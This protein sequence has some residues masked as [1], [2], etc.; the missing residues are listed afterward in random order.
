MSFVATDPKPTAE[1]PIINDGFWPDVS[2][3]D[4]RT[5]MRLDT[6]TSTAERLRHALI[7]A[8]IE[9]G[10]DVATWVEEQ[11]A[12]GY[13]KL[14]DVPSR[15]SIDGK[16]MVLHCY[17]QAVYCYAK[18]SIIDRTPDYDVTAAG[19]RKVEQLD[20]AAC[21]LR[22]EAL[23]AISRIKARPRTTVELI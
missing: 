14:D 8:M 17:L 12:K 22:R 1:A 10:A 5:A 3:S 19:Q 15:V 4:A 2:P 16:S 6:G 23:W 21:D 11:R 7:N 20:D 13:T 18:A 9:V